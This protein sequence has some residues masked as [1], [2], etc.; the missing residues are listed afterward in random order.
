MNQT[1]IDFRSRELR[2]NYNE[3]ARL[4]PSLKDIT[5]PRLSAFGNIKFAGSYTGYIR[6][7][8]AYGNLTTDIGI[9]QADVHMKVPENAQAIYQGT[10]STSNFQLGKFIENS[11]IG[12][13]AF[14]GKINGKGFNANDI[15]LGID[16]KIS[17]LS[18][19]NYTYT[20]IIAH[21]EIR[22]KLFTGTASIN[23]ANIKIDTLVG[24][25]N[26]SRKDPQL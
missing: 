8:V 18:F 1:F 13:V 10:I 16:G 26:F 11:Q 15:N 24:S 17:R 12:N 19:N 6:D 23:D 3:L 5:N 2:T 20:N 9:L 25:I 22:K 4:I 14:D 7:F 21:G